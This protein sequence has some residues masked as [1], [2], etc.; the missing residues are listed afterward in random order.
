MNTFTR[1]AAG[2]CCPPPRR[3]AP[4]APP[5]RPT[6]Q[7]VPEYAQLAQGYSKLTSRSAEIN[8]EQSTIE[9]TATDRRHN[10]ASLGS[11]VPS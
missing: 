4:H 6:G 1:S 7:S 11:K 3:R 10:M 9:R 8:Q 5:P 2:G